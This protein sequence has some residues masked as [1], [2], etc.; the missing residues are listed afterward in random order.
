MNE[1]PK[2]EEPIFANLSPPS[3]LLSTAMHTTLFSSDPVMPDGDFSDMPVFEAI[4]PVAPEILDEYLEQSENHRFDAD[5]FAE[6]E[7]PAVGEEIEIDD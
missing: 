6:L 5:I 2:I 4:Q 7:V 3:D 1:E